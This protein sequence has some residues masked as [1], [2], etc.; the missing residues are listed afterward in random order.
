MDDL[1]Y[2]LICNTVF[3]GFEV[4]N[5]QRFFRLLRLLNNRRIDDVAL[6]ASSKCKI[7]YGQLHEECRISE[8]TLTVTSAT[9][10]WTANKLIP[11]M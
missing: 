6:K 10:R 3:T 5:Q 7:K 9:N 11:T 2:C 8:W 4:P 1:G